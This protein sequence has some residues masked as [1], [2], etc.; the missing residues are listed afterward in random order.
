MEETSRF[1][2]SDQPALNVSILTTDSETIKRT[3]AFPADTNI[4]WR[5][6]DESIEQKKAVDEARQQKGTPGVQRRTSLY[7]DE[8]RA[9]AS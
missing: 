7:S 3:L 5:S 4:I 2:K 1:G 8:A 6:H 9:K